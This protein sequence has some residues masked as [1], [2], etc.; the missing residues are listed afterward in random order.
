MKLIIAVPPV[1]PA[2]LNK[3]KDL[4]SKYFS[5]ADEKSIDILSIRNG[6]ITFPELN[7]FAILNMAS[8]SHNKGK[9]L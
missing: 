9:S 6:F 3:I 1:L 4:L 2:Y 5:T 8:L 7:L